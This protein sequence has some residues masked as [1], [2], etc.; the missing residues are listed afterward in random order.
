MQGIINLLFDIGAT[1][2]VGFYVA[3]S[4]CLFPLLP[5]FL[6]RTLN[7]TNT[8]KHSLLISTV[9]VIG[10]LSSL[11]LYTTIIYI[12]GGAIFFLDNQLLLQAILGTAIVFFGIVT[13]SQRLRDMLR[14]S[15][16]NI[17]EH[18]DKPTGLWSVFTVGLG[19]SLIAA[20]C[21]GGAILGA[22]GIFAYQTIPLAALMLFL[23]MSLGVAIPYLT[24]ALVT[25]ETRKRLTMTIANSTR[26]IEIAVG[27]LL[28][29][30]GILLITP[31]FGFR[32][33]L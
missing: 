17:K 22:F 8:R 14:L 20:P 33:L 9:L 27:T 11:A 13:I 3:I 12:I 21:T 24:L 4:P 18:P 1:F 29:I 23:A 5:L 15:S 25:G 6:I 26:K 7:S 10:I 30:V 16:L 19:Y 31:Y 28:I 2:G 32:I